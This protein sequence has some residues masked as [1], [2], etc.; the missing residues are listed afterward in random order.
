GLSVRTGI[1]GHGLAAVLGDGGPCIGLRA[2]M[3]ALPLQEQT[4]LPWASVND[5]VM[6]ACGHDFHTA[7][8]LGTALVLQDLGLP[9]GSVKFMFQPAEEAICGAAQML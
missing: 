7:W 3:D 6:H 8:L 5:G 1:G 9:K 4:G 2:D